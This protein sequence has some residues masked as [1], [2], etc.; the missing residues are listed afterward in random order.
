MQLQ[1]WKKRKKQKE[2]KKEKE[3]GSGKDERREVIKK[4]VNK[5]KA[6]CSGR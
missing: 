2:I 4:K 3:K 6:R 5:E 1:G